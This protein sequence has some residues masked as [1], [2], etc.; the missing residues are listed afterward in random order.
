M[1]QFF[2]RIGSQISTWLWFA[3]STRLGSDEFVM[4]LLHDVGP[5]NPPR[6]D[7]RGESGAR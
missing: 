1:D 2:D 6:H 3:R 4:D 7:E 5:S